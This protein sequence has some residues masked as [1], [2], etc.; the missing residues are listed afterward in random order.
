MMLHSKST[1]HIHH[2]DHLP[3]PGARAASA[4]AVVWTLAWKGASLWRAA[5]NDS[6]PWFAVLLVSNTL[7]VLDAVYLF[8]IDRA[9]RRRERAA[10]VLS[11][12]VG[13]PSQPCHSLEM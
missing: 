13:Q 10:A 3:S 6:K 11:A 2:H 5:K 9:R 7:G 12:A 8:G 4:A 1:E